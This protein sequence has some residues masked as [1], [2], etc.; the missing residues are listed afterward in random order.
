MNA[1]SDG[2]DTTTSSTTSSIMDAYLKAS[3]VILAPCCLCPRMCGTHES[4]LDVR[5]RCA[6]G[7]HEE[8][9]VQRVRWLWAPAGAGSRRRAA[10]CASRATRQRDADRDRR[11]AGTRCG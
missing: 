6:N 7:I 1:P 11:P 5:K 9:A 3:I 4:V 10:R 2:S 8:H